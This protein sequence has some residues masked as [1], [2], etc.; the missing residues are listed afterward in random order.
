M[1][2]TIATLALGGIIAVGAYGFA[3]VP[4]AD[5]GDL[6]QSI[7]AQAEVIAADVEEQCQLPLRDAAERATADPA[8]LSDLEAANARCLEIGQQYAYFVDVVTAHADAVTA[9]IPEEAREAA[10][11]AMAAAT[12]EVKAQVGAH[13]VEGA[14]RTLFASIAPGFDIEEAVAK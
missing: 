5:D 4:R 14:V 13:H 3:Q 9:S 7:V 10:E 8:A 6:S 11:A 12:P 2:K 1:Y